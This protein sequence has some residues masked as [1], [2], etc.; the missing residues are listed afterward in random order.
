MRRVVDVPAPPASISTMPAASRP[1]TNAVMPEA[2]NGT[3]SPKAA[4]TVTAK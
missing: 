3:E 1:P 2:H 4:I